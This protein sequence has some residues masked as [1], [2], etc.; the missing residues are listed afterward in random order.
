[1]NNRQ[2]DSPSEQKNGKGYWICQLRGEGP[3]KMSM[4]EDRLKRREEVPV[5]APIVD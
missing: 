2:P 5:A 4:R 3:R 1:M